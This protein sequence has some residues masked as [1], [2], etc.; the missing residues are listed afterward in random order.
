MKFDPGERVLDAEAK[1]AGFASENARLIPRPPCLIGIEA[2]IN[3]IS[4]RSELVI[5]ITAIIF[6]TIILTYLA[7][8]N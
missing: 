7:A 3:W 5:L 2:C 6:I 4:V 8:R 1:N